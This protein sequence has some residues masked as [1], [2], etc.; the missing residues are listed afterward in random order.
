MDA[1]S[2]YNSN[3]AKRG[4]LDALIAN[5][6]ILFCCQSRLLAAV[7]VRA[8]R[9]R[10]P[11]DD[12]MPAHLSGCCTTY[13]EALDICRSNPPTLLITTQLLE[14][15]SGLNLIR[16]AK[17]RLPDL[18]TILFLQHSHRT[19][20]EE[21][22]K[23]HSD[24]IVL[25]TEI[26]SGH[27]IEALKVVSKGGIYI[28]PIIAQELHGSL[29]GHDP[30]LTKRELEVMQ[31]VVEGLNDREIGEKLHLSTYTVKGYLKEIYNKLKIHNRTRAAI[32]LVL[33][34]IV[35]PPKN[36]LRQSS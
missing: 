28:E 12:A 30:S 8:E 35:S 36:L 6:R 21:A 11:S 14:E 4:T 16:D 19:L 20:F 18:R 29:K 26:G 3:A 15:G 2:T 5:E 33:L 31:E 7:W 23:T 34:G 22:I 32:S 27:V 17:E 25:E 1:I 13:A 10:H 9:G 24:G